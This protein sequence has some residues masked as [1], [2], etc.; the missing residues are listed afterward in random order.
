MKF[1]RKCKRL[2]ETEEILKSVICSG[3]CSGHFHNMCTNL[4]ENEISSLKFSTNIK[5]FCEDCSKS[6]D[7]MKNDSN[8][9]ILNNFER[10][11]YTIK[12]KM[13]II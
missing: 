7:A 8:E 4:N 12:G 9:N 5:W 1:C 13:M 10:K 11:H 2:F 3:P 6:L